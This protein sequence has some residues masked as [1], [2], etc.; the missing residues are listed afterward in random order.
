MADVTDSIYLL[1]INI[2]G[3][4]VMPDKLTVE[5]EK[6]SELE[7]D[8]VMHGDRKY[9]RYGEDDS[10]VEIAL[11]LIVSRRLTLKRPPLAEPA[12]SADN[13]METRR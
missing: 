2:G 8:Y 12:R 10:Y 13:G 1:I 9:E 5:S 3:S 11:D 4:G 6:L 7:P